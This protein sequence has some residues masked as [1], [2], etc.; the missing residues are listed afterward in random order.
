[1]LERW[2]YLIAISVEKIFNVF[3]VAIILYYTIYCR[4]WKVLKGITSAD[5]YKIV[6][7][8]TLRFAFVY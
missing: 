1:M 4:V 8:H 5:V 7:H 2:L 3:R 6:H